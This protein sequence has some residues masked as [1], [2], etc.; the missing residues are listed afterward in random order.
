M[1][2]YAF[3]DIGSVSLYP[4]KDCRVIYFESALSHHLLDITLRKQYH[5][6]HK[7]MIVGSKWRHL[8]EDLFCFKNMI[9]RECW[10]I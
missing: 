10:M 3:G 2:A 9:P 1:L 6:T 7:R 5:P 4:A 8:N